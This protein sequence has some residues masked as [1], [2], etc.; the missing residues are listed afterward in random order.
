MDRL[1]GLGYNE[2]VDYI[3]TRDYSARLHDVFDP[4]HVPFEKHPVVK[5][6]RP[7]TDQMWSKIES[8]MIEHVGQVTL[9]IVR[10]KRHRLV[11]A[12]KE[13]ALQA[14]F[15]LRP[16]LGPTLLVPSPVDIL[17]LPRIDHIIESSPEAGVTQQMF[18]HAIN[19][20]LE[21]ELVQRFR[22]VEIEKLAA[23][24]P[25]VYFPFG[26]TAERALKLATSVFVCK[27]HMHF[28]SNDPDTVAAYEKDH[29]LPLFYP[30]FLYHPCNSMR[31][32][33]S[34]HGKGEYEKYAIDNNMLL[35]VD[36]QY[37]NCRKGK[38]SSEELV[39]HDKARS[40]VRKIL[41]A[42]GLSASRTTVAR[43]DELDPRL[44]C[45]KCTYGGKADGE[46]IC[47]VW[48][49]RNAV[50]HCLKVHWGGAVQWQMILQEDAEKAR[51]LELLEPARR[52][53]PAIKSRP[54]RCTLC[55]DTP[56]DCGRMDM[57]KLTDHFSESHAN[58][59]GQL[60]EG[61]HYYRA[62]EAPLPRVLTVKMVPQAVPAT[63]KNDSTPPQ[64]MPRIR[65]TADNGRPRKIRG[66]LAALRSMPLDIV[67]ELHPKDVLTL[68]RTSKQFRKILLGRASVS[69]WKSAFSKL[70]TLPE[71]PP[72][73]S[74]P[75][76]AHLVFDLDCHVGLFPLASWMV[77][78]LMRVAQMC[79]LESAKNVVD[80]ILRTNHHEFS[81]ET[82]S[83]LIEAKI[84]F[85]E[86]FKKL[87]DCKEREAFTA[88][89][90]DEAEVRV[91]HGVR[92]H[93][94]L[95]K[96]T[97]KQEAIDAK[98]RSARKD[99]IID[100]LCELG[101]GEEIDYMSDLESDFLHGAISR[102][103]ITLLSNVAAVKKA[104]PLTKQEWFSIEKKMVNYMKQIRAHMIGE[105]AP[106]YTK[107]YNT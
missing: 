77:F 24:I 97:A 104:I 1:R 56:S 11:E 103:S 2:E 33:A 74:Y 32:R 13:L 9:R 66:R 49:W 79:G 14:W 65:I 16:T 50:K 101:F 59:E 30:E 76:W 34:F 102:P 106:G 99:A 67:Y 5:V 60:E 25:G 62:L 39:T 105:E 54:W 26:S 23:K 85:L 45:L 42:C 107:N 38:W 92:C 17:A 19:Q 87:Q 8:K 69:I 68:A 70:P 41:E 82:K 7:L 31:R 21:F 58:H 29:Q 63:V 36:K 78:H 100:E 55:I 86:K 53:L 46:R 98:I 20:E 43:L 12:R 83:C 44:I 64:K 35:G 75:A 73:M 81:V 47:S 48:S 96:E 61:P 90:E 89:A 94:W 72:E 71:C 91:D 18:E 27:S 4:D 37:R 57:E 95:G 93:L 6:A 88:K 84:K 40:V 80:F 22:S 15:A 10:H 3:P 51:T 52:S 28:S